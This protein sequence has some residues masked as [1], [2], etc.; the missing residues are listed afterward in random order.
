MFMKG[1]L[2][3]WKARRDNQRRAATMKVALRH[4]SV[5]LGLVF[6]WE[7]ATDVPITTFSDL[8]MRQAR[9]Y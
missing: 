8:D 1:A 4:V 6:C 5:F 7:L 2:R 9:L 3:Q